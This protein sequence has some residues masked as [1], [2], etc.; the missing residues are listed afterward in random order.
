MIAELLI[1]VGLPST[2]NVTARPQIQIVGEA[3]RL[4]ENRIFYLEDQFTASDIRHMGPNGSRDTL[5]FSLPKNYGPISPYP[6][7]KHYVFAYSTSEDG[8]TGYDLYANRTV[9]I[10]GAIRLTNEGFEF[11][12]SVQHSRD[13]SKIVFTAAPFDVAFGL[14]RMTS[15]GGSLT[16]LDNGED[17]DLARDGTDRIVYTRLFGSFGEIYKR[18][19]NAAPGVGTRLTNNG[20]EDFF[21]QWSK[22]GARITFSRGDNLDIF[23][24]N[25]SGGDLQQLTNTPLEFELGSSYSPNGSEIA[26]VVISGLDPGQSGVY[27]MSST[28]VNRQPLRLLPN[29]GPGIYW[30]P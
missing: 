2:P 13:G 15:T 26:F 14:Y 23:T 10:A 7:G 3:R 24:M 20:S 4:L 27:K 17:S 16:R 25:S 19:L 9:N 22:D 30:T 1:L 5:L 21:P 18:D 11:I 8:S 12:N 29:V 6:L 28:G